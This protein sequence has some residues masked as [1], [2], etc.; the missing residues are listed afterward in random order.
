MSP[1]FVRYSPEIETID[2]NIEELTAEIVDFWEKTVR[3]SPTR[4]GTGRAVRGAHAKTL[5]VV[6]AEVEIRGGVP[7]PHAQ[8]IYARPG[9]HGAL[10]RFS[11]ANNHLGPDALLGSVLGFAIKIF[12]VDGTKLVEDAPDS[13]TFDLVLKNRPTFIANTAKHY[14]FIQE[15]GNDAAKYLARGKAGFRELLT[16]LL[17][18]KGTLSQEEWAWEEMFAFVKAATETPVR[19]PLLSTYSTMGAVRHGD[20]VA[21]LRVAPSPENAARAIHHELDLNSGP[22]VFGPTV[23]DELHARAFD[24]D[25]QVQLCSDLDAMPV[26]DVT[27]EWPERLSP[28]VTVGRVHLPRQDISGSA[29]SD[30]GD[31]LAFNQWR[32]TAEHQPLGEIMQVRRIYSTSAKVRRTLN[33]QP[34]TEPTSADEVLP[35]PTLELEREPAAGGQA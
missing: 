35:S 29:N 20:Y 16:D 32:V 19:N 5:G 1:N 11:M 14:L 8:G 10:I 33:H 3:E 31:A 2:P 6:K 17:T 21:K 34:Q 13:S 25:L 4:E 30:K 27:V 12:D 22:D 26:N 7:A 23:A 24:F 9:R 28:F 15:I 18:G